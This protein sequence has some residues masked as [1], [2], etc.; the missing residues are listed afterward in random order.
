MAESKR[1]KRG[2]LSSYRSGFSIG[3]FLRERCPFLFDWQS[4]FYFGVSIVVIGFLFMAAGLLYNSFSSAYNWDYSHQYLPFAYDYRDT[5]ITFFSTGKFPL[6]DPLVFIG[7]DNI[8]A[9]AYYGLFDP[10]IILL[11]FF[12]RSWIPQMFAIFT[13][14][15]LLI[16]ALGA[17]A[18]L[19]YLGIREWTARFGALAM[20]FSGYFA[21]MVGFP[22]FVSAL[23][24]VPLVLLGIEKTIAEGK[25][26]YLVL[27]LFM[28]EV[29]CFLLLVPMCIWGVIYAL[30]R[31]FLTVRRRSGAENVRA[32]LLGVSG[33]ALGLMLGMFML[34]P[35]LRQSSLTGR[36]NSIGGAYLSCMLESLKSLDAATFLSLLFEEVGDNPARELMPLIS[37]LFPTAGFQ[38]LPLLVPDSSS[39]YDAW[40]ASLYCYTPFII[41]FFSSIL[42]SIKERRF[43]HLI[44]IL[45]GMFLLF[46]TFAYYFFFAFSGNGYGRWFFVLIPEIIAYGCYGFDKRK[47][48]SPLFYLY[49]AITAVIVT[50]ASYA[51]IYVMLQNVTISNPNGLTYFFSKYL[52]PDDHSYLGLSREYYL[53]YQ[54]SMLGI[55][56]IV[57]FVG[58]KRKWLP[59]A[60]YAVIAIEVIAAGN[61]AYNFISTWDISTQFM[62]GASSL[63]DNTRMADNIKSLDD[64]F[65]RASFD[66]A[67]GVDNYQYAVGLPEASSFHSLMNFEAEDFAVMNGMKYKASTQNT[68]G[69]KKYLNPGWSAQYRGKR[70]GVDN[71][72]GYRYY[73]TNNENGR[74]NKTIWAGENIPFGAE[75]VPS[76]S[77]N[78]YFYRVYR[79]NEEYL[80]NLGHA[81][82]KSM[83]YRFEKDE[84]GSSPLLSAPGNSAGYMRSRI[85]TAEIESRGAVFDD[86]A[87]L[88]VG[89]STTTIPSVATDD[90]L[91]QLYG[92]RRYGYGVTGGGITAFKYTPNEGDFVLPADDAEYADEG[93]A[94]IIDN[95]ASRKVFSSG[96]S[97]SCGTD[98]LVITPSSG[99]YFNSSYDGAYIEFKYYNSTS[100]YGSSTSQYDYMPR[101]MAI[102]ETMDEDGNIKENQVLGFEGKALSNVAAIDK[103]TYSNSTIGLYAHGRVKQIVLIWPEHKD[104][105]G[106]Y[107]QQKVSLST[108]TFAIKDR[109]QFDEDALYISSR[110][111]Q[112][113]VRHANSFT[114]DT[115]YD[116]DE[117]V[118]T[119]LGYDKGWKC[120]ATLEDGTKIDCPMY[121]LNGGLVGFLAPEGEVSYVLSYFTPDLNKGLAFSAVGIIGT[122]AYVV[123]REIEKRRRR[124][125]NKI[126]P[127][128]F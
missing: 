2:G 95:Y 45:G 66:S 93:A 29:S 49:G 27:G 41:L 39:V 9:N 119:Q 101:V 78:R 25:I 10:F 104:S 18:Y 122:A 90:A 85:Q 109:E 116:E 115:S 58:A 106:A 112:N 17:R 126:F 77:V 86:D 83:L 5:W 13:V 118:C 56:G 57:M 4:V 68:Y 96:D 46:T 43:D 7:N 80:P 16:C 107:I 1:K 22:S 48:I 32:M 98:H 92:Y 70:W 20:A 62:G 120:V 111:L 59:K 63:N 108:L 60:L 105:S 51:L 113:V 84:Y 61:C 67:A 44:A 117:I 127:R 65:Y 24:Y 74:I 47:Q 52:M 99:P 88:P 64:G 114:F 8:G 89:F 72:L 81:V 3:A 76:L 55:I 87:I 37:F 34:L 28:I 42:I 97:L 110:G 73:V 82:D 15:K 94:Y 33:F 35:S 103:N 75:E 23:A 79:V 11:S 21:F 71:A 123:Y 26:G 69:D 40:T 125:F 54:L 12:P 121:K 6:Y 30:W 14:V 53:Y 31:F 102:G 91:Y 36:A 38:T 50:V 100:Y 19:K 128:Q 124:D